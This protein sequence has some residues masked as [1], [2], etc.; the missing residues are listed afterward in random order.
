MASTQYCIHASH[1]AK[2]TL[3]IMVNDEVMD[4][5]VAHLDAE[6]YDPIQVEEIPADWGPRFS[7]WYD[8]NKDVLKAEYLSDKEAGKTSQSFGEWL[9]EFWFLLGPR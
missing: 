5:K 4:Q 6:G 8:T 3:I 1:P 9:K 2:P 7:K